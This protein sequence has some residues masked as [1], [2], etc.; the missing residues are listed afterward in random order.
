MNKD[1]LATVLSRGG[2]N[3]VARHKVGQEEVFVADGF[4]PPPHHHLERFGVKPDEFPHGCYMTVWWTEHKKGWGGMSFFEPDHD[5]L[6]MDS[7]KQQARINSTLKIA[8][9][10]IRQRNRVAANG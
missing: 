7:Y 5:P 6:L 3:P 8:S 10:E 4:V 2:V 9:Y 1:K